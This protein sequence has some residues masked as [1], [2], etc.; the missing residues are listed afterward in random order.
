MYKCIELEE[1]EID[2]NPDSAWLTTRPGR[3]E[4]AVVALLREGLGY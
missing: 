1:L 3:K 4:W 2:S